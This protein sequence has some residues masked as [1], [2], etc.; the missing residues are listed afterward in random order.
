MQDTLAQVAPEVIDEF[1]RHYLL[2]NGKDIKEG[3]E[4]AQ[5]RTQLEKRKNADQV[6]A[7]LAELH[8]YANIYRL[9][10]QPED[11]EQLAQAVRSGLVSLNS[12]K[13]TIIHPILLR[14]ID[15]TQRQKIKDEELVRCMA[16]MESFVVRRYVCQLTPNAMN[17]LFAIVCQ[18]MPESDVA[19]WL[20]DFLANGVGTSAWPRDDEF[21]M[22]IHNYRRAYRTKW[23][24]HILVGI[25]KSFHHKEC[26]SFEENRITIEHIMPQTLNQE[27]RGMLGP[28]ADAMHS[29][30][31]HCLGNLTLSGYNGELSN[32]PFDDKKS[33]LRESHFE[34]NKWIC[35]QDAWTPDIIQK[36]LEDLADKACE[37]WCGPSAESFY[38]SVH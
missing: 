18:R 38:I 11:C 7:E 17:K 27:W 29:Q 24:R 28:K 23:A 33:L 15:L 12:L 30:Y 22:G 16:I 10:R 31:L 13:T 32:S 14:L 20:E 3:H 9:I 4:Y 8:R 6:E 5:Y 26:V 1:L 36:R 19:A 35:E 2:R 34:I 25:E 21:K 37:I